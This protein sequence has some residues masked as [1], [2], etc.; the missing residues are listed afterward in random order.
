MVVIISEKLMKYEIVVLKELSFEMTFDK[1]VKFEEL[2]KHKHIER[3]STLWN[4][5]QLSKI[6]CCVCFRAF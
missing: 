1:F 6:V 5:I 4:D 3:I 2:M